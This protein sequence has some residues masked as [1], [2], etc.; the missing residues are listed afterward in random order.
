MELKLL[1]GLLVLLAPIAVPRVVRPELLTLH[2]ELQQ[3]PQVLL[4]ML[5]R[6]ARTGLCGILHEPRGHLPGLLPLHC[7]VLMWAPELQGGVALRLE[8]RALLRRA[9]SVHPEEPPT[10][11]RGGAGPQ[12]RLDAPRH[13]LAEPAAAHIPGH[14]EQHRQA[15]QLPASP[16]AQRLPVVHNDTAR[17]AAGGPS[18]QLALRLARCIL[19]RTRPGAATRLGAGAEGPGVRHLEEEQP[20]VGPD[21]LHRLRVLEELVEPLVPHLH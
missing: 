5:G 6:A 21:A 3:L 10:R 4:L 13:S 8:R 11:G 18:G 15:L 9:P 12:Q 19:G 7:K 1:E 20:V 2:E 14:R 17:G 16:G